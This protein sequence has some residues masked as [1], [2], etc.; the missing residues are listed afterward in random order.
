[1]AIYSN[2]KVGNISDSFGIGINNVV[3]LSLS[4]ASHGELFLKDLP[5]V[6]G[7][8][9]RYNSTDNIVN[10]IRSK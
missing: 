7:G 2:I 4:I 3:V 5:I 6:Y 8:G 1:M 9:I 10:V